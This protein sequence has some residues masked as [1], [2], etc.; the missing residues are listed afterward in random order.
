MSQ[1]P[2]DI[3]NHNDSIKSIIRILDKISSNNEVFNTNDISNDM[4]IMSYIMLWIML[5]SSNKYIK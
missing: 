4:N 3:M 1:S 2:L 5:P